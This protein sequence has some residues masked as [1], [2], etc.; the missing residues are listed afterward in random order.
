MDTDTLDRDVID[1]AATVTDDR[2]R[3]RRIIAARCPE[4]SEA[5]IA[6]AFP[7][8]FSEAEAGAE[9]GLDRDRRAGSRRAGGDG[10]AAGQARSGGDD[11]RR[12]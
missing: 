10:G 4:L 12:R 2:D 5:E 9:F 1:L 7:T 6:E 11:R 3:V 8:E